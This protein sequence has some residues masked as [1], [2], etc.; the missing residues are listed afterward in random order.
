VTQQ[1]QS[2]AS[3]KPLD[4][5]ERTRRIVNGLELIV[6]IPVM[7]SLAWG[8]AR[9]PD[10]AFRLPAL[11]FLCCVIAVELIPIPAWQTV[12]LSLS[13]PVT[14]A[15]AMLYS[16]V[17]AGA[18]VWLGSFDMRDLRREITVRRGL[19]NRSQIAV[20]IMAGSWVFHQIALPLDVWWRL[21]GGAIAATV[22]A[23]AIN[24]LLVALHAALEHDMSLFEVVIKMHGARPAEFLGWYLGLAMLGAAI[25]RF[26]L[27]DGAWSVVM[28]LLPVVLA[29]QMYFKNRFLAD[30]LVEQ[31]ELLAEQAERLEELLRKEHQTVIDLRELNRMKGDFVAVV[32][33]EL[34]TP[35]T[36]LVGYS[37]T[38]RQPQFSDDPAMREEFLERMER[39]GDRLLNLVE[40]LLTTAK[41]ESDEISVSFGRM[42]FADLAREVVEGFGDE[43]SRIQVDIP[44]DLPLLHTDRELLGRVLTNLLDNALKYSPDG[45]PCELRARADGHDVVFRVRDLG[46]GIAPEQLERIFDRFHQVDSSNTRRFPGA[47]LGLSM[48]SDLLAHLGGTITVESTLRGGSTFTVRLPAWLP[49]NA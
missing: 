29:R 8:V 22:T 17:L 23:Y 38:L 45:S 25:A 4:D 28:F 13:F 12:S 42:R 35:L 37:K 24:T 7:A 6:T 44:E 40:N 31:N 27:T 32:S 11:F 15:I 14:I 18:I 19:W 30:R 9:A 41:L 16:P 26:Y 21:A 46:I 1:P 34:R 2:E 33:H 36:A 47:G 39:Q 48:V 43:A 20:S 49:A 3:G 10:S 5:P